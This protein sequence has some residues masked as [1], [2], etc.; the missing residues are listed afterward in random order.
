MIEMLDRNSAKRTEEIIEGDPVA[1]AIRTLAIAKG[2]LTFTPTELLRQ[3]SEPFGM[4]PPYGWPR[5]G[6]T[7]GKHLRV[8]QTTLLEAGIEV[9]LI[10][11]P[12]NGR[13]EVC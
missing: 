7:L 8:L 6:A 2:E 5:T 13:H 11:S 1:S 4:H 3:L 12:K 10:W 9:S